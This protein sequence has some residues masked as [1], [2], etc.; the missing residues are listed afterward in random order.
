MPVG[1]DG[2]VIVPECERFLSFIVLGVWPD[3]GEYY[4]L[5]SLKN[6]EKA[7]GAG[8]EKVD[9]EFY[10]LNFEL[11]HGSIMRNLPAYTHIFV[12]IPDKNKVAGASGREE[13]LIKGYLKTRCKWEDERIQNHVHFFIV[14]SA[15]TWAQDTSE[16][17]GIDKKGRILIAADPGNYN[18]SYEI[19]NSMANT[20]PGYFKVVKLANSLSSEGGDMEVVLAPDKKGA[21][22]LIGRNRVNNYYFR[23]KGLPLKGISFSQDMI[24][25]VKKM[26][27]NS[28]FGM[29]VEIV[30]EKMLLYPELAAE[31]IFH[32]DMSVVIMSSGKTVD[33]FVPTYYT[34]ETKVDLVSGQKFT[35]DTIKGWQAEYDEI[36]S[37]L[38]ERGYNVLRVPFTDHPVR[39]P[40]NLVK[41][42]D[43]ETGKACV[44]LGKYPFLPADGHGDAPQSRMNNAF[45]NLNTAEKVWEQSFSAESFDYLMKCAA[46][47]WEAM[48]YSASAK[49]NLYEKQK[50][51]FEKAGYTVIP[52]A[53]Y[54]WGA[55]GLHCDLQF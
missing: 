28:L 26:Y 24:D 34:P 48:D 1:S 35:Q 54:P 50:E 40:A 23:T 13:A 3:S 9:R 55:G 39:S 18:S 15:L 10:W 37:E 27:S 46:G 19:V 17:I 5:P 47:L 49:N 25:D 16:P 38:K 32:L 36:A 8:L 31:E 41:Y 43:R 51:I 53:E 14:P 45:G 6:A 42:R 33:A 11:S 12:A 30:P 4:F 7:T 29:K 44:L 22:F 21:V 20:Y 2:E 52:V